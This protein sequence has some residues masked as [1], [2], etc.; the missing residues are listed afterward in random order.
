[1]VCVVSVGDS[2]H[3]FSELP[4]PTLKDIVAM[5]LYMVSEV[6]SLVDRNMVSK[7]L[8]MAIAKKTSHTQASI[9]C[10]FQPCVLPETA[11]QR[12]RPRILSQVLPK[13]YEN[14]RKAIFSGG[15][16]VRVIA[17]V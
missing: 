12:D 5:C 4:W 13:S 14:I 2:M 11:F 8:A 7:L 16:I 6:A 3:L 15:I 1:M 17:G 10:A 9:Q